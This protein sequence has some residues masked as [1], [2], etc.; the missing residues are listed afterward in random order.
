MPPPRKSRGRCGDCCRWVVMSTAVAFVAMRAAMRMPAAPSPPDV[1]IRLDVPGWDSTLRSHLAEHGYVHVRRLLNRTDAEGLRRLAQG[2][3]YGEKRKALPLSWGGYTV[4]GFLELPEFI[5]ARWLLEDSRLH[6][7]LGA[8]FNGAEYRFASHNDIGCDFVGVWHK[9]ILRGPVKK[10]QTHDLWTPDEQGDRHEIYKV[11]FYLQDHD[12]D[13][14]SVKVVPGSHATRDISLERGYATLHPRLG[15]AVV[16][17]QRISHAGNSFYDPFGSGRMFM[18]IGFGKAN[19][20]TDEFERGTVERQQGYQA[21]MLSKSQIRGFDTFLVDVK[22]TVF[23][24]VFAALP[25]QLLNSFADIDVKKYAF[26]GK[27]I[28]GSNAAAQK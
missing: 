27:L 14:R 21:K 25:P 9:D 17:D 6:Q 1:S 7:V 13:S 11:L 12:D 20:F 19:V 24:M 23:G 18:Q 15:D 2:Y 4:P 3:C 5:G 28:F 26:I 8:M 10:Y 22:F 16:I